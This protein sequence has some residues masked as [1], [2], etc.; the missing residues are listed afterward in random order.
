MV[1]NEQQKTLMRE[2]MKDE[3]SKRNSMMLTRDIG[4]WLERSSK[5]KLVTKVG[6]EKGKIF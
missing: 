1:V 4:R 6:E 2:K 5:R 3:W